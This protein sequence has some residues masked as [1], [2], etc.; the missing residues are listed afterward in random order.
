MRNQKKGQ[1]KRERSGEK[2]ELNQENENRI[3]LS[4]QLNDKYKEHTNN[5]MKFQTT[6]SIEQCIL[7]FEKETLELLN[8]NKSLDNDK[9]QRDIIQSYAVTPDSLQDKLSNDVTPDSLQDKLSNDLLTLINK[10]NKTTKIVELPKLSY[11]NSLR[12]R[13]FLDL[14]N[15]CIEYANF[16]LNKERIEYIKNRLTN[17]FSL[18]LSNLFKRAQYIKDLLENALLT[19]LT[20]EKEFIRKCLIDN[21]NFRKRN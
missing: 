17:E 8:K 14:V 18:V 16:N 13:E 20:S 3:S 10:M 15:Q 5:E 12:D 6:I 1:N 21:F 2:K 7:N 19:I 11:G 9:I 4:E